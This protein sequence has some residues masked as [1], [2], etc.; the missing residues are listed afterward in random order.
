MYQHACMIGRHKMFAREMDEG[1][2][3][4]SF[5]LILNSPFKDVKSYT[6][7]KDIEK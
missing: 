1:S 6:G 4:S 5:T 2:T 3:M 7:K